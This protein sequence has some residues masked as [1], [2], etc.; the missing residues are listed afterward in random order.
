MLFLIVLIVLFVS[1]IVFVSMM[2]LFIGPVMLL[3]PYRRTIEYYR[4]R[5]PLLNP[6]DAGLPYEDLTLETADGSPLRCWLVNAGP[7]AKGTVLYLHGVSESKIAGIPLTRALYERGFNVFLYD[8]RRH[9]ESGGTYCTYGFY[10]KYDASM[11][12]NHLVSRTDITVGKIGAFGNSMGAAVALQLA[13]ID[14]RVRAIV[15]ESGFASLRSVFD[16]YQKRMVKLPWHYLRNLVIR[17]S[18]KIAHFKARLVSPIE[19]VRTIRVP[20][21]IVHGTADDRIKSH[22]SEMVFHNANEPKELWLIP[23]AA[24]HNLAEIG[25]NEYTMKI[26]SFFEQTLQ[27][28]KGE[29][30]SRHSAG[31]RKQ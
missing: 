9:G 26:C 15:A 18:E 30:G 12:I 10:E 21:L 6:A 14:P 19:S 11:V 20:I 16:D 13:G 5:T 8:S 29:A 3:Q 4:R 2:L 23:N 27:A 31:D 22:Y 25:G 7:T 28:E 24:H 1:F 17:R